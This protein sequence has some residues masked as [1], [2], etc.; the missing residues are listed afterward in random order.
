MKIEVGD[1]VTFDRGG[2][3]IVGVVRFVNKSF[4]LV[5]SEQLNQSNHEVVVEIENDKVRVGT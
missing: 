3:R 5:Y 2:Q 4:L 1:E